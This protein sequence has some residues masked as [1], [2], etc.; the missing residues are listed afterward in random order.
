[1]TPERLVEIEADAEAACS[2]VPSTSEWEAAVE[3]CCVDH[4]PVLLAEV[5]APPNGTR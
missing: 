2:L 5:K 1:M 4:M 3:R